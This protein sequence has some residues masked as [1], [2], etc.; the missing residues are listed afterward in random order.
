MK[1]EQKDQKG[2]CPISGFF[3]R[4]FSRLDKKMEEKAKNSGCCCCGGSAREKNEGESSG[5]RKC[6]G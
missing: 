2:C 5:D 4:L 1:K 6:S 3:S